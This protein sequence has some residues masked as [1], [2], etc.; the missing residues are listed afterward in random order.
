M[1]RCTCANLVRSLEDA[2][3]KVSAFYATLAAAIR[4][5]TASI[6][7]TLDPFEKAGFAAMEMRA[8]LVLEPYRKQ[9][10]N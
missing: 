8:R 1:D 2:P 5:Q 4:R 7:K 10:A 6:Y 9:N 3:S